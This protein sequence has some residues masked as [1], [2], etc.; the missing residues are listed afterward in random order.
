MSATP[1]AADA[2]AN[3]NGHHAPPPEPAIL[4]VN[5]PEWDRLMGRRNEL[6]RKMNRE[7]LSPDVTREFEQI[8]GVTRASLDRAFPRPNLFGERLERIEERLRREAEGKAG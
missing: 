2:A 5:M 7:G 6:I 3:L 8:Q 4:E 1:T